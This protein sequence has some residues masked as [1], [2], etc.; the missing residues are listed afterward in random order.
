MARSSSEI[1]ETILTI[2][3]EQSLVYAVKLLDAATIFS[4]G[5]KPTGWSPALPY[6]FL[7]FLPS[8]SLRTI[9]L[10][11]ARESGVAL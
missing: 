9:P 5:V 4:K 3:Y 11:P 7:P 8:L 2:H 10:N 6:L 1:V